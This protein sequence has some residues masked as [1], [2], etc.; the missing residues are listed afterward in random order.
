MKFKTGPRVLFG[1][2]VVGALIYGVNYYIDNRP[3]PAQVDTQMSVPQV[4]QEAI[5]SVVPVTVQPQAQPQQIQPQP[6]PQDVVPAPV[7]R[8]DRAMADLLKEQK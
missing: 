8:Q 1:V 5:P 2:L 6:A 7:T 3:K 4:V